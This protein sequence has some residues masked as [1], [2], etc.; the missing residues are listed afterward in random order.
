MPHERDWSHC[1]IEKRY[2]SDLFCKEKKLSEKK[3]YT[4]T[5]DDVLASLATTKKGLTSSEVETRLAKYGKNELD[6]GAKKTLLM[7]FLE[8]GRAHV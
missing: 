5:P 6:A 7:K 8:I 3:I 4:Q 1:W 2:L